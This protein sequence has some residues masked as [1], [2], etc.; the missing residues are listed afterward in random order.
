[1]KSFTLENFI[2]EK[3]KTVVNA[4][5]TA[6]TTAGKKIIQIDFLDFQPDQ[7][8]LD[9]IN[10][11]GAIALY[12]NKINFENVCPGGAYQTGNTL[13]IE[14]YGVGDTVEETINDV[15]TYINHQSLAAQRA[16][17]LTTL[18]YRAIMDRQEKEGSA[19]VEQNFGSDIDIQDLQPVSCTKAGLAAGMT[20]SRAIVAYRMEFRINLDDD[21]PYEIP[22][23]NYKNYGVTIE[24][25][26]PA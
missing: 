18:V 24:T 21:R 8:Y 26:N 19:T 12:T 2:L 17:V 6:N 14:A 25:Q 23:G 16:K 22:V 5:I 15:T 11:D 4:Y 9:S 1:M 10:T 3:I 13:M 20:A 7:G